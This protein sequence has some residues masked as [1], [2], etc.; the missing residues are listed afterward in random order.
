MLLTEYSSWNEAASCSI[1]RLLLSD[2]L[3]LGDIV[4]VP[5]IEMAV[6]HDLLIEHPSTAGNVTWIRLFRWHISYNFSFSWLF[7][8]L[9]CIV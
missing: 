8:K 2:H 6:K 5:P 9:V 1:F 3:L 4:F 7:F